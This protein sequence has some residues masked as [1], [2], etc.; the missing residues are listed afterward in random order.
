MKAISAAETEDGENMMDVEIN[1][2][3][4]KKAELGR[5]MRGLERVRG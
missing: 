4:L 5:R 1:E 2:R 3:A